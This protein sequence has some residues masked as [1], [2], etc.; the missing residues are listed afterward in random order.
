MN[1]QIEIFRMMD[2]SDTYTFIWLRIEKMEL[3][4]FS[5]LCYRDGIPDD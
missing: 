3:F 4:K 5:A 1:N 2:D